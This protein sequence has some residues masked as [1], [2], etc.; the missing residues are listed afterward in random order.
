MVV[1]YFKMVVERLLVFGI[2][3]YIIYLV[4]IFDI[5]FMFFFVYGM[6]FY[7]LKLR[8]LVRRLVLFVVD[9]LRV[10]KL[11]EF[12]DYGEI[13]VFYLR[14]LLEKKVSWGVLYIRVL[15]EFCFGYVVFIVGFYEDVSVVVKGGYLE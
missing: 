1:C 11:F 7:K 10:D 5:Y 3:V 12:D 14:D 4:F 6:M 13:C 8:L 2:L 9:G 15:I